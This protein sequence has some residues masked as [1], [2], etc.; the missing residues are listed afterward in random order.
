MSGEN[1]VFPDAELR[2]L[3]AGH[4]DQ[5]LNP[6]EQAVLEARLAADQ[7]AREYFA[8][9]LHF[10]AELTEVMDAPPRL[11]WSESR[12]IT[13]KGAGTWEIRREQSVRSGGPTAVT[14]PP[15]RALRF[16]PLW[17][18]LAIGGPAAWLLWP[19]GDPGPQK[20]PPPWS[21]I[22]LK[23]PGFESMDLTYSPNSQ[24]NA[25][26]G[27]QDYYRSPNVSLVEVS[28]VFGGDLAAHRGRNATSL[29]DFSYLTQR[30]LHADG[31]PLLATPGL[32]VKVA[33]WVHFVSGTKP[34]LIEVS[35]RYV[36]AGWPE[37]LQYSLGIVE[38]PIGESRWK[39]FSA[40]FVLPQSLVTDKGVC[41]T[42]VDGLSPL[43]VN[44]LPLVLS[45]DHKGRGNVILLD[46][47]SCRASPP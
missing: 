27:W 20:P 4:A 33:G 26:P 41:R 25:V 39:E 9:C 16:W 28:R 13:K 6:V 11:Q 14:M 31:T 10:E 30:L 19:R 22:S 46:D 38:I 35:L 42:K 44:G 47:M 24:T 17:L 21:P 32:R 2:R 34:G 29:G 1:E 18:V 36:A 3:V 37:M 5:T 43:D 12:S 40:E 7:R 15:P 45:I 8:T 23:N